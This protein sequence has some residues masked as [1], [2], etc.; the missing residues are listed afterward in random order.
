MK[1]G[2]GRKWNTS[3]GLCAQYTSIW[4]FSHAVSL[5]RSLPFLLVTLSAVTCLGEL[6][7]GLADLERDSG[8]DGSLIGRDRVV[9]RSHHAIV[10]PFV[11]LRNCNSQRSIHEC[12]LYHLQQ[13]DSKRTNTR[14]CCAV[15]T[16]ATNQSAE[17][18]VL[19]TNSHDPPT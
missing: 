6:L 7:T 9:G 13:F 5:T 18:P 3:A 8:G 15:E 14:V 2:E 17:K 19:S 11:V 16:E 1:W 12:G 10:V 4:Q